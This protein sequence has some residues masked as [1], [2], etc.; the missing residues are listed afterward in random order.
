M[1]YK[2]QCSVRTIEEDAKYLNL[3]PTQ[4]ESRGTN[5]Y[6]QQDFELISQLRKHCKNKANTRESFVPPTKVEI[7]EDDEPKITRINTSSIVRNSLTNNLKQIRQDNPLIEFEILNKLQQASDNKWLLPTKFVA[8][9]INKTPNTLLKYQ[10]YNHWGFIF[11][12]EDK[13]RN[14]KIDFDS[15][16][17][18][19][20]AKPNTI[21]WKVDANNS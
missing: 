14:R 6:S 21:L 2:L 8:A 19:G 7:V 9:L 5:L 16:T 17:L 10:T 13:P 20:L 3:K 12:R 15:E 4:E 18:E 1:A 11:S